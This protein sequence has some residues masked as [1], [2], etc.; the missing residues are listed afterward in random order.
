[1]GDMAKKLMKGLLL[2]IMMVLA[3]FVQTVVEEKKNLS[4]S[5]LSLNHIPSLTHFLHSPPIIS[6]SPHNDAKNRENRPKRKDTP[7]EKQNPGSKNTTK[8]KRK[9]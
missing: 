3:I 5:Y 2:M 1:M 8:K 4:F 9:I 7:Q 6:I